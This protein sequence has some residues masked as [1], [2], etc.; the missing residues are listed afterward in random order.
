M[1]QLLKVYS[2][3]LLL[4]M[5]LSCI[6]SSKI[7][8]QVVDSLI[9]EYA[10]SPGDSLVREQLYSGIRQVLFNDPELASRKAEEIINIA[11]KEGQYEMLAT[12]ILN[13]GIACDLNGKY[14]SAIYRFEQALEIARDHQMDILEG[15]IYNNCGIVYA[16][17]GELAKALDYGLKALA[18][19]EEMA[20]SNR[21][22][23][24]YN[25]LGS[26]YSEMGL[27]DK[28]LEYYEKAMQI[29][30][31]NG[32]DYRLAHNY[33]N[34]GTIY[35]ELDQ[36]K[37]ALEYYMKAYEIQEHLNNRLDMAITLGNMAVAYQNLGEYEWSLE[38]AEKAYQLSLETNDE[39]GKLT[40][41]VTCAK[42]YKL[43][44]NYL[45]AQ[46]YYE[47]ALSMARE[48]GARQSKMEI[49]HGL[50]ELYAK[51]KDFKKAFS[52]NEK[53]LEERVFLLDSEKDKAL[54]MLKQY[55]N[56]KTENEIA[57]L[58]KDAEIQ[59]LRLKRQKMLR[60]SIAG[61]GLLLLLIAT[62]LWRQYVF[63][64]RTR[65]KLA[66][67]NKEIEQEKQKSDE[68]LLNIL[69]AETARELKE[70]GSSQARRFDMVSVLFSDFVDFTSISEQL[71]PEELVK[72]I[73]HCFRAF[74]RIISHYEIE[75]IKTIGDAYMCA[76]GLPLPNTSNPIDVVNA[77]MDMLKFMETYKV[78]RQAEN[79]PW[80][81]IR[82][83]VHTGPVVAGIVGTKKFAYDI[84]GDT[85]N[86]ASRMESSGEAGKVNVSGS[87]HKYIKNEFVWEERGEIE[88]KSM[89]M[90]DMYFVRS[91]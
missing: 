80:F 27:N 10:R 70:N 82:I 64:K 53:Y 89:G 58:T 79:K 51:K 30:L 40:Y 5:I 1:I 73:D 21:L 50:A 81:E 28:G 59:K 12:M 74:D 83:G 45:Q 7:Q 54:E 85:V 66:D 31:N 91:K 42:T 25:N 4:I 56:I 78:E 22:A 72:Q 61:I 3:A 39:I 41:F 9:V 38:Y 63:V 33:G 65:N 2:R 52:F 86:T 44:G 20:D 36:N 35:S 16:Y 32:D 47:Q 26:R 88:V 48:L 37:K 67:K 19:Y 15:D 76:G 87:T 24:I 18:L 77:A 17:M 55:E 43:M 29:N 23:K 62:G 75:K 8:A 71:G 49:Y 14:D 84:W 68:L 46:K 13:Q 60:N 69:P 90:V 11:E 57:L 34:M 6:V